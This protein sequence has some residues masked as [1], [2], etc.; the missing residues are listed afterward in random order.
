MSGRGIWKRFSATL[1]RR[2]LPTLE[3]RPREAAPPGGISA[4]KNLSLAARAQKQPASRRRRRQAAEKRG[5]GVLEIDQ[6]GAD[7]AAVV[8]GAGP[9]VNEYGRPTEQPDQILIA[10][11]KR[12][13]PHS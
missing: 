1:T 13:S 2:P 7:I 3:H 5:A 6:P 8:N 4:S 11:A 12:E 10:F 9:C